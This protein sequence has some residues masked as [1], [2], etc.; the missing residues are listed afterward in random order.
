MLISELKPAVVISSQKV[1]N[2][3]KRLS[4][5]VSTQTKVR[6]IWFLS[7]FRPSVSDTETDPVRSHSSD[8]RHVERL[9]SSL[10][11]GIA[12]DAVRVLVEAEVA[13]VP[14]AAHELHD[15][16]KVSLPVDQRESLL[17]VFVEQF[18]RSASKSDC[19]FIALV[20]L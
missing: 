8:A 5:C 11:W 7:A 12:P 10:S 3:L 13:H 18:H 2:Y 1:G 9:A 16:G 4:Y 6:H 19:P 20:A 17:K 15:A 14:L